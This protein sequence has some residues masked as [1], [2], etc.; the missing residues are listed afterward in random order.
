MGKIITNY[1]IKKPCKYINII[2]IIYRDEGL[3]SR[4]VTINNTVIFM[5]EI[6]NCLDRELPMRYNIYIES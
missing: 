3:E 1:K 6:G 2:P 4:E 5:I